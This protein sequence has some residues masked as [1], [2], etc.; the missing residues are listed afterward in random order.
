MGAAGL[1]RKGGGRGR[2]AAACELWLRP[3]GLSEPALTEGIKQL[4][5]PGE[6][7]GGRRRA[8]TDRD[9][10][11]ESVLVTHLTH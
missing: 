1:F 11:T 7:A 2:N 5:F 10:N 6:S 8:E 4:L 9:G 3:G